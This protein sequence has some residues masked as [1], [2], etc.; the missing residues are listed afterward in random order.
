MQV[1]PFA[2]LGASIL[3]KIMRDVVSV[4]ETWRSEWGLEKLSIAAECIRAW[5]ASP[6]Q[7]NMPWQMRYAGTGKEAWMAW[8]PELTRFIQRQ[9]FPSEQRHAIQLLSA[10]SIAAATAEEAVHRLASQLAG[11]LSF[12]TDDGKSMEAGR[13]KDAFFSVGSGALLVRITLGD[14]IVSC[15]LDHACVQ[16]VAGNA[17]PRRDDPIPQSGFHNALE[18]ISVTLPIEI[19]QAEVN[20]ENLLT[21]AV[22]DVI[23]LDTSVDKPLTVVGPAQ[24]AL[25]DGYL[26]T[27]EGKIAIEVARHSN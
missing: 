16:A 15:L 19:G 25:F 7:R 22:G 2:L 14:Q 26:G 11:M 10:P 24:E 13:P 20:V 4:M 3:D 17:L 5:E 21:L 9:M 1:Q 23:R 8:Q 6:Q 27:L 18:N 12:H